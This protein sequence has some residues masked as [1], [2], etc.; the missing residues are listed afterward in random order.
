[1]EIDS[2][3]SLLE[4]QLVDAIHESL[5]NYL[6]SNASFLGERLLAERDCEDHRN[7]L[8]DCYLA[9]NKPNK[10]YEVL[11]GCKTDMA[12]Y[13]FAV[14]CM[15]INKLKDGER[16]LNPPENIPRSLH[17]KAEAP[18]P[19]GSY[20]LY[21]LGAI[22]ERQQKYEEAKKFYLRALDMNP[23]LWSAY[24]RLLKMGEDVMPNRVFSTTKFKTV[25]ASKKSE[26]RGDPDSMETSK[27]KKSSYPSYSLS[28]SNRKRV[29]SEAQSIP[30][31]T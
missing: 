21:L 28:S 12:R 5:Q 18:V 22:N 26:E 7:L 20:G 30:V 2:S 13:K 3:T 10:A 17:N 23:T 16:A 15:R 24:E 9:E 19:N 1:M 14:S 11:K 31:V 27:I 4:S 6:H 8:A 29:A 25:G